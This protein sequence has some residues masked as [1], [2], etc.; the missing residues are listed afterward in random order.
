[1]KKIILLSKGD[2]AALLNAQA[3]Y[4]YA[5]CVW[6]GSK[7]ICL[8]NTSAVEEYISKALASGKSS[9]IR[10]G[11]LSVVCWGWGEKPN[12][13]SKIAKAMENIKD[14]NLKAF[15]AYRKEFPAGNIRALTDLRLNQLGSMAFGTK[16]V[17]FMN[18]SRRAVLDRKI[19][20]VLRKTRMWEKMG[21]WKDCT[22]IS[23]TGPKAAIYDEWCRICGVGAACMGSRYRAVDFERA[24]FVMGEDKR[25]QAVS[26]ID[27][28]SA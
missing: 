24:I 25:D 20:Y 28:L 1:M 6:N 3:R 9:E 26:I 4:S 27:K 2:I 14:Y 18:L 10:K 19:C 12:R 15:V 17:A 13:A 7:V 23:V 21:G 11:L 5:P 16:V 8:K 22:S